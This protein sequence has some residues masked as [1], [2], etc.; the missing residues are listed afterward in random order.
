MNMFRLFKSLEEIK[1]VLQKCLSTYLYYNHRDQ[2]Y[3]S[4]KTDF[5]ISSHPLYKRIEECNT[6]AGFRRIIEEE[7]IEG[8]C[9]NS[10]LSNLVGEKEYL[11]RYH[12]VTS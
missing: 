11:R 7:E 4:D 8:Y 3:K 1:T 9:L 2:F 5:P 10:F 12:M 6:I